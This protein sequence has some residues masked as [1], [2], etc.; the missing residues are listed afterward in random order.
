M[1]LI[2]SSATKVVV[3]LGKGDPFS[4]KAMKWIQTNCENKRQVSVFK[5][6]SLQSKHL[7]QIEIEELLAGVT[8]KDRTKLTLAE[9]PKD[10]VGET[11][12]PHLF[13]GRWFTRVWVLQEAILAQELT[14]ALGDCVVSDRAMYRALGHALEIQRTRTIK[15]FQGLQHLHQYEENQLVHL[16]SVRS[17][18]ESRFAM[19][20][21]E[22]TQESLLNHMLLGWNRRA[23]NLKDKVYGILGLSSQQRRDDGVSVDHLVDL[24]VDYNTETKEVF[25]SASRF[26]LSYE[27]SLAGL[28][29]A[30]GTSP[31]TTP[32][33]AISWTDANRRWHRILG[34]EFIECGVSGLPTW[35]IDFTCAAEPRPL[36]CLYDQ[37]FNAGGKANPISPTFDSSGTILQLQ[38]HVW[39]SVQMIGEDST[40]FNSDGYKYFISDVLRLL[41][42]IGHTYSPT[43][44]S[45]LRAFSRT[46]TADHPSV[47]K[48]NEKTFLDCVGGVEFLN[49]L[50]NI[51]EG[52]LRDQ[53]QVS[54]WQGAHEWF[55]KD[56]IYT[57][58]KARVQKNRQALESNRKNVKA[59]W[60]EF[61]Q[62]L[63]W[64][65]HVQDIIDVVGRPNRMTPFWIVWRYL[66]QHRRVFLTKKGYLGVGSKCIKA[67]DEAV[68]I[69]GAA[70]PF[71]L[72][73]RKYL[74]G[75]AYVHGITNGEAAQADS[76]ELTDICIV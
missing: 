9:S 17:M 11:G 65:G 60:D 30:T 31:S 54:R 2:Y 49:E 40:V 53:E 21:G 28:S 48:E 44:E 52:A 64:D 29:L 76:W 7:F 10:I 34:S 6:S 39:D 51:V 5:E 42:K 36:I 4:R 27:C 50:V 41:S 14:F 75:E 62:K 71:V 18:F 3:W 58:Q 12:L 63:D 32:T 55:L 72:R 46:I 59:S 70:V 13:F 57:N 23:T 8:R 43:N 19:G 47:A 56:S 73:A 1:S 66:Y 38:G 61:L 67:G 24:A 74:V 68:I 25:L 35:A 37:N 26:I 33:T 20:K 22:S 15:E 16:H 45:T 69:P